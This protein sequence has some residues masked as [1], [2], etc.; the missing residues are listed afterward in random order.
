M[1]NLHYASIFILLVTLAAARVYSILPKT[2]RSEDKHEKKDGT[3][4]L[5][6]F[7]GS[8]QSSSTGKLGILLKLRFLGGHTTEALA[9]VSTLDFLRYTPRLY[10]VSEGDQLSVQKACDLELYKQGLLDDVRLTY[11]TKDMSAR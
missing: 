1:S 9:L 11:D 8:G 3:C 2:K 4:S 6:V 7:L 10:V 5:A